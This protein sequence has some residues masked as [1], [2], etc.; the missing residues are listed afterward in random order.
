[1]R[2]PAACNDIDVQL[3]RVFPHLRS[4]RHIPIMHDTDPKLGIRP[5]NNEIRSF[6]DLK[7]NSLVVQP[8][9]QHCCLS[10]YSETIGV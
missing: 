9:S 5:L 10:F 3:T 2:A 6:Q 4:S 8:K 1:M 7:V